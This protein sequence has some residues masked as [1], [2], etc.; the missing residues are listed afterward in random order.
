MTTTPDPREQL[1][2]QIK[3]LAQV[4]RE[5]WPEVATSLLVLSATIEMDNLSELNGV[6]WD[7]AEAQKKWIE[8][9]NSQGNP[10]S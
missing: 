8:A 2:A 6:L 1:A 10:H 5:I 9:L 3:V 4:A 7:F